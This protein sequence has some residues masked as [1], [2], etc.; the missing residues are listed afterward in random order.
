MDLGFSGEIVGLYH[1]FRRGYPPAVFDSI[2]AELSLSPRDVVVD[3]GCGT[4]QLALPMAS[5]V[6]AVVGI[7]PSPDMLARA[8]HAGAERAVP[9]V[10]WLLGADADLPALVH[11]LGPRTVGA[12][13]VGQ[14]LHWMDPTRLF[15]GLTGLIRPGGGVAVVTNGVPLWLQ[16]ASWSRALRRCLERWF[17][18]TLDRWCG[19]DPESQRRY[20]AGLTAAGFDVRQ[21]AV[22]YTPALDVDQLIGGVLSALSAD[23]LPPPQGRSLLAEEVRRA[24][25]PHLPLRE[26]VRVAL[27][28]GRLA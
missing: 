4:G 28:L 25:E 26:E 3:L 13:T 1:R 5:R 11:V 24:V 12:V 2:A 7:D 6:R 22:E 18:T 27:I 17:D 9:N 20:H 10:T 16:D 14:A 21:T 8:R 15:A 19:T 23:R